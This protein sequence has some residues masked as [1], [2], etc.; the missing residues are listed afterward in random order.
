MYRDVAQWTSIR[1]QVLQKGIPIRRVVRVNMGLQR[2]RHK[3][4]HPDEL[5]RAEDDEQS[6]ILA[7]ETP[8]NGFIEVVVPL[9]ARTAEAAKLEAWRHY[10]TY[11][12]GNEPGGFTVVDALSN[13]TVHW[14]IGG[15]HPDSEPVGSTIR[16]TPI[17]EADPL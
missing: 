1:N 12:Y 10:T 11:P 7:P 4:P 13:E 15:S 14:Q 8:E 5:P 2:W 3:P 9:N 17:K 16:T 6:P